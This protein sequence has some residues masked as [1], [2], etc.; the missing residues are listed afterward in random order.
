MRDLPAQFAYRSLQ[1]GKSLFGVAH[2]Q[3]STAL[4]DL[5]APGASTPTLAVSPD[6]LQTLQRRMDR[7]LE[8]DWQDASEGLYPRELLFDAPWGEWLLLYPRVWL[9]LPAIWARRQRRDVR[10]LPMDVDGSAFPD[11]YL[12]NFHHQ[13]DGYLSDRSA[14]L[15]DLQVEILFNGT[16]DAMR[17]RV[18]RPL[19]QSLRGVNR[20][21]ILDVATGTGR[22]LQQIQAARP[23]ASLVGIDLSEAYLRQ[24]AR[25]LNQRPGV[26][27]QLLQG[28]AEELPFRDASF[29]A[30]T[31]VFLLHELPAEA[32][33]AMLRECRRVLRPG[34]RL[35]LADSIQLA[36]APD[37]ATVL[38]N[39][40]RVFHEPY[41]RHYISDD[42]EARIAGADLQLQ[43]AESWFMTRV[44]WADRG[45]DD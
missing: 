16:A 29:D 38:E 26:L 4:M 18:L 24:A 10:D 45:R 17:R 43:G 28:N 41:Y 3:A 31:C 40:R 9:D 35:V 22:T 13:T 36:D 42:L 19:V 12:Q 37:C 21:R 34:G 2:K 25:R 20:P 27:P 39:F 15:Y 1:Q 5:V 14:E 8:R 30:V 44:W 7:L 6:L 11:Y 23:E 33:S 32:R